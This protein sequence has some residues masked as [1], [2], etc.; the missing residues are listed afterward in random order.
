MTSS[1]ASANRRNVP[2]LSTSPTT[3]L[4]WIQSLWETIKAAPTQDLILV[5]PLSVP[6]APWTGQPIEQDECYIELYLEALRLKYARRFASRFHVIVYAFATLAV[7][8]RESADIAAI[9]KSNRLADLDSSA[10]GQ[11][12]VHSK[13]LMGPLPWR[14]GELQLELGLFSVQTGNIVGDVLNF[15]TEVSSRAGLSFIGQMESFVPL[16]TK[17]MNLVAGQTRETAL[18]VGIDQALRPNRSGVYAIVN[19]DKSV[20]TRT[21]TIDPSDMKLLADGVPLDEAYCVFSIR[22]AD[23][24][25]DFGEIPT[26]RAKYAALMDRIRSND[27]QGAKDALTAFRLEAVTSPDLIPADAAALVQKAEG[28]VRLAFAGGPIA[29][30]PVKTAQ[31]T[32]ADL[33]LY[34]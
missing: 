18:E 5:G 32:L 13:K 4:R 34:G 6:N 28:R 23:Q 33:R 27:M 31:E 1:A 22:R 24:K 30:V 7:E 19:A 3:A 2:R 8:G 26:L 20:E 9:S 15:V 11:V 16:I 14:G 29:F 21:I 12:I 17:G 10:L 25:T